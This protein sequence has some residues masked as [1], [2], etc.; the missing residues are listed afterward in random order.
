MPIDKGTSKPITQL[1]GLQINYKD[2]NSCFNPPIVTTEE[3]DALV[4]TDNPEKPIKDGTLIFNSD[5]GYEEYYSRDK[6]IELKEGGGGTG[7]VTGPEVASDD[8]IAVFSG[9]TGKKIKDGGL[10]IAALQQARKNKAVD[11]IPLYKLSNL[12]ALQ[13][14]SNDNVADT[15]VI[16]VDGLTPVT[17]QMQGTG[18]DSRVCTIIN[19][20]LGEGSSSPSALLE[21]NSSEGG[22]LH[23]RMTTTQ[24]DALLDPQD[25][26][27]IYNT[28]TKKL[29][30]RQDSYW[31]EF[32]PPFF[33][34]SFLAI[35]DGASYQ[36]TI[37]DIFIIGFGNC[38]ITLP[39]LSEATD[40]KQFIFKQRPSSLTA[41]YSMIIKTSLGDNLD[42]FKKEIVIGS[43]GCLQIVGNY[44]P[45]GYTNWFIIAYTETV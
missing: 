13:F 1:N 45:L 38:T 11:S 24:R 35:N 40:G 37:Y 5:T 7:D 21:I 29:N 31:K 16:L 26:L 33:A 30:V 8:N 3:R 18:A 19:G 41:S 32:M 6:W 34:P 9:E 17:F 27:V 28:D 23:A 39:V 15:G 4:N 10:K 14:G 25:G 12:G 44:T 2:K 42:N 20:E 43:G 36:A 22:L